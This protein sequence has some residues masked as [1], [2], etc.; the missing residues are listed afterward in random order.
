MSVKMT[1]YKHTEF[2]DE[3]TSSVGSIHLTEA[4]SP[5]MHIRYHSVRTSTIWT[6]RSLLEKC[7]ICLVF[8]LILIVIIL[9]IVLS[10][11]GDPSTRILHVQPHSKEE[12]PCL[13]ESCIHAASSILHSI[14]QSIDPCDNFYA[15]SCNQWIKNNPIPDG[16][17]MWG[18]F[19]KLEQ[20]NQLVIKNVLEREI[21]EFKSQA[22]IKA[23][24]YYQSCVDEDE[25]MEQL[26]AKPMLDLLEK[27][28]GWNVT[29]SN[30]NVSNWSLE[31]T[32]KKVQ[33]EYN[34]GGLFGW[35]VG[36]DDRKS[37]RHVIQIDQGGL[38]LPTR[39]NYLNKTAHQK[40]LDA[41][42][43]YMTK[44]VVLLGANESDAKIQMQ[45]VIDFETELAKITIPS[46]ERRDEESM[47]HNMTLKEL[48]SKA[49]FIDWRAHFDDA[50]R[51]AFIDNKSTSKKKIRNI[52]DKEVV[53]V[54]A[55]KYLEDLTVLVKR[56]Q[57]T[58]EGKIIL[59]NYL[60]WQTVRSF[61]ACL[62]KVF[63]DAYKG[64]RKAL[65]GSDGGEEP[66]RYCVTD[67]NNAIGFAIGAMFV[68]EAF[69]GKS[70]PEAEQM[71]NEVRDAFKANLKHLDWMDEETRRLANEKA[72]A[73]TDMIGYPGYILDTKQ[74]DEKY[75]ELT[76]KNDT[77]FQN[78]IEINRYNLRKNLEK[79]DEPVNKTRWGMTPPTVNAYYT[80]T[81]N[82]IVFPA[83]I[84]QLPF[85]DILNPKSL[86][87]GGMGVVMGHEITH[88]FDDQ[89]R[90]YDKEGNLHQW[91][92]NATISRFK[93]R[94]ECFEKQ[95]S[96]FSING[97]NLNGKQTLGENIADNGG[98][99]AAFHAFKNT[100]KSID[101]D[102]F[103]LPGVWCT[104]ATVE[105]T[106]LQIEKDPHSPP[107]FRV[108]GSLSNFEEFA[109]EFNCARGTRMYPI[110]RCEVW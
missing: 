66:W 71:I 89:G 20:Q 98:L 93:K 45:A 7:L 22:E 4:T 75:F 84:L 42:L 30:F 16:K 110:D 46:E 34:M 107:E 70:K 24:L 72:D 95:Y 82:Q 48:Q 12:G 5:A 73:I 105:T 104:S 88:G 29:K 44:V 91:W 63:R 99:K 10:T 53:V 38:G 100:K 3:D 62:S 109:M 81:K 11:E 61:T 18:T 36:E 69:N 55:P 85:Y 23:K 101:R 27:L 39:D 8:L 41:Y 32:L 92:N 54:Y 108:I 35:A 40:V 77:Y 94:T 67:T 103:L 90:E 68:R 57:N 9:A 15:Y 78:N 51:Q 60:I 76:I 6:N 47:Y 17:S 33:N 26:G 56:Y 49:N 96:N 87:F 80:P 50:F 64:L 28:G 83:G 52:T 59:N 1:R 102:I 79:L 13:E 37:T 14:D 97:R 58:T 65:I 43:D 74:L 25:K 31:S 21:S 86:N 106:N 2:N 19:G